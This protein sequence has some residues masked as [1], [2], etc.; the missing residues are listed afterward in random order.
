[1]DS[2][3]LK[4]DKYVLVGAPRWKTRKIS[5]LVKTERIIDFY[6]SD[7]T[8]F[9]YLK[10]FGLFHIAQHDRLYANNNEAIVKLFA[11]GIGYGTLTLEVAT[12][13]LERGEI[14]ILNG[15]NTF[16]DPQALAWYPRP[17]MPAY[18]KAVIGSIK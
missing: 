13:Y 16:D 2:K 1:M 10:K 3:V 18:F 7:Q 8:T 4:A 11:A 14:A 9:N 6:E 5:E 17:E 15:K 12:P